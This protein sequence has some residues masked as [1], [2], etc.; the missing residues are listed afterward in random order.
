MI[1]F[2]RLSTP[3]INIIEIVEPRI[4]GPQWLNHHDLRNKIVINESINI[5]IPCWV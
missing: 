5:G 2:Y 1:G 4:K 3:G